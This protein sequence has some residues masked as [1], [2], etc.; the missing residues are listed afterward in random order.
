MLPA[1]RGGPLAALLPLLLL[2]GCGDGPTTPAKPADTTAPVVVMTAPVDTLFI[3]RVGAPHR[4]T[5][6]GSATDSAG[7]ARLTRQ[8]NG[9][10]EEEIGIAPGT[11]VPYSFTLWIEEGVNTITVHAYDAAGNRGST[12]RRFLQN[13][14]GPSIRL[15]DPAAG[16]VVASDS[17]RVTLSAADPFGLVRAHVT[18]NNGPSREVSLSGD[19][20]TFQLVVPLQGGE[21]TIRVEAFDRHEVRSSEI[22]QVRRGGLAFA[23]ASVGRGHACAPTPAG[24]AYCWA[25]AGGG[26]ETGQ[27]TGGDASSPAPVAGGLAFRQ[28]EAGF[29]QS[30]GVAVDGRAHC[31]GRDYTTSPTPVGAGI[32]FR[33]VTL[34]PEQVCGVSTGDEAYCWGR[35][36]SGELGIGDASGAAGPTPVAGG[37]AFRSLAAGSGYTCG[38]TPAGRAYCWGANASGQLGTGAAAASRTPAPVAGEL[39]FRSIAAGVLH[40]CAVATDGRAWCWG[41]NLLGELGTGELQQGS[42]PTRAPVAVRGDARFTSVAVGSRHGCALA[43][44]G[45][46]WCWGDNA[47]GQLGTGTASGSPVPAR[48]AGGHT[49]RTLSARDVRTCGTTTGNRLLCWGGRTPAPTPVAGQ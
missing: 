35:G 3:T 37:I 7:V 32:A 13:A 23:A 11:S 22:F 30:C 12:T 48:V 9:G 29:G 2:A 36:P 33:S 31:W 49:F 47:E 45:A 19:S 39:A 26:G 10:R 17:A 15:L 46:A 21:N 4:P 8:L 18:V 24:A 43:E 25:W 34:G 14:R 20:T 40:T 5:I 6:Q 1:P 27:G 16:T 38:L 42:T 28:V 41:S 44:D